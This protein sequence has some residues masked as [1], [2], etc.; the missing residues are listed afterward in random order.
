MKPIVWRDID[1]RE[2]SRREHRMQVELARSANRRGN[3]K[4][5][6]WHLK[7]AARQRVFHAA[8]LREFREKNIRFFDPV[9]FVNSGGFNL[10]EI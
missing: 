2:V 10:R 4:L 8:D 1:Y 6:L 3:T 7:N 9:A 5:A